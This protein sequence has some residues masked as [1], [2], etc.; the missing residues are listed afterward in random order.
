[1]GDAT[2]GIKLCSPYIDS[3]SYAGVIMDYRYALLAA[4]RLFDFVRE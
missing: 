4:Q 1:M 3:M 2:V